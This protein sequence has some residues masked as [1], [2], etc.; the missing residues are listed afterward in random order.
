MGQDEGV[1]PKGYF[2]CDRPE[3]QDIALRVGLKAIGQKIKIGR[4]H[5]EIESECVLDF[6]QNQAKGDRPQDQHDE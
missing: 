2:Q 6:A 5:A 3:L 4:I 1:L